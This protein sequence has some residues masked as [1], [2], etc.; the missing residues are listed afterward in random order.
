M[1]SCLIL[2]FLV[3][4]IPNLN[5]FISATSISSTCFIVTA[6]VSSPYIIAGLTTVMYTFLFTF[7]VNLLSQITLGTFL[8]PF[9][10]ACTLLFTS[11]S[12]LLLSCTVDPCNILSFLFYKGHFSFICFVLL[13][14][15][16]AWSNYGPADGICAAR[17]TILQK[18]C[19]LQAAATFFFRRTP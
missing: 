11:L 17:G 1:Y 5:I 18:S 14:Y 4:P 9:H 2:S 8:Y 19:R 13:Y 12:Q 3:T 10:S 15:I 7:A 16:S 6:T